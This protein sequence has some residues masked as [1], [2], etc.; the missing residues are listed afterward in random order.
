MIE[1][2]LG[3]FTLTDLVD[4]VIIVIVVLALNLMA[5]YAGIP[6][7][8]MA[9]FVFIGA[10]SLAG[11]G[12]RIALLLASYA[13][14]DFIDILNRYTFI[15]LKYGGDLRDLVVYGVASDPLVNR[16][17]AP[18]LEA[19]ISQNLVLSLILFVTVFGLAIIMGA[20]TGAIASFA[21]IRLREDYLAIV[22]LAFSEMM[23]TVV[24]D[25]TD[26]LAGGPNGAYVVRPWPKILKD[27]VRPITPAGISPDL[28]IALIVSL[29]IL[30][31]CLFYG[32][33]IANSPM[34]RMLRAMRDD[35]LVISVY[36]RDVPST[37]LKIM[38]MGAA[39]A[40]IAGVIYATIHSPVKALDYDRFSW[41][42][43]PWAMMILGG[44]ANNWGVIVGAIIIYVGRRLIY[45]YLPGI[46]L[47][48]TP[49]LEAIS[50]L[51]LPLIL[52]AI[53][54]VA[55]LL[56]LRLRMKNDYRGKLATYTLTV[57]AG[58][59]IMVA[60][61]AIS[62]EQLMYNIDIVRAILPNVFVGIVILLV[63][64]LRPQGIIPEKPSRTLG[65]KELEE[66]LARKLGESE[67]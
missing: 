43:T 51:A 54:L 10:F 13:Y 29:L 16:V 30:L 7:F 18:E 35:D 9:V 45:Y 66:I 67:S 32:E 4:L 63:L 1:S 8:G 2:L 38:A 34:G 47:I 48:L 52:L 6:N 3:I 39:I 36:G 55:V 23:V 60:V 46:F 44:M 37:R 20:L 24:F 65:R 40:S 61:L 53:M 27:S 42:F 62:A 57:L 11:I 19:T 14:P 15:A 25:Q 31:M 28:T 17:A 21:A 22:L 12:T 41:T 26:V 56:A 50:K 59:L 49:T 58:I 64:Y 5:G 33:R